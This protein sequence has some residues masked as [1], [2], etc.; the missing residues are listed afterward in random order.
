[1]SF[2]ATH[3]VPAPRE[4]VW[5]WH[6]RKGAVSRLSPSFIPM[7]PIQQAERLSDGTTIFGLPAGLRWTSRHDLSR[8]R[9]G[10]QFTDVCIDAPMKK[11]ATW[12]HDHLF[13]D[14]GTRDGA[15]QSSATVGGTGTAITDRLDTRI[16]SSLIEP[17]FA[18]RQHQLI[19]DFHFLDRIAAKGLDA[20]TKPLTVAITGSRGGVGRAL[21]AQLTTAGHSVIQLVRS[22][23][24][25]GQ[26]LWNPE[27]PA[28]DLLDGVDVVVHL[29]GEPIFGRFNDAHKKALRES[30]IG[31][32]TKLAQLVAN[33]PSVTAM[34]SASAIGFYGNA[35]GSEEL[36]EDS[37]GG[38]GFLADLVKDWE[39]ATQPAKDAGKRVALIRTGVALS[40]SSGLLPLL[41]M[42]FST[43]LGGA[44]GDGQFWFSWIAMDDLTDI[45]FRAI[46]DDS[47]EGP[48]NATAPNPV[49][50]KDMA[51]AIGKELGRPALIP[52]PAIGP[53]LL[54]G[55]E[56]AQEL[57][58][59]DQRVL[60]TRLNADGHTFRYSTIE[61][62]LAHE[63]G[64]EK[65]WSPAAN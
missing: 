20:A 3:V 25:E 33:S 27:R 65:L 50:N 4:Q 37:A 44:F 23:V 30:R 63:L 34:V 29:A 32:T 24:K 59:A 19:Q 40:G 39:E 53:T 60:P 55:K 42:L 38:S 2:E 35:R 18:Y 13:A 56:G 12:R 41:R 47:L 57:A 43:G 16:P 58:L 54:L 28:A 62:A 49:F 15:A 14:V 46:V 21:A 36:H 48:I 7:A 31:P 17:F 5:Q 10:I 1:M 6:T 8:Y 22:N 64:G 52:I 45:Y 51:A 11:L 61:A 26:R 9:K